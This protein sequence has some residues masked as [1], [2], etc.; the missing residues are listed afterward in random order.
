MRVSREK[1]AENR[2]KIL[3]TAGVM[4]RENGFN[5][6]GVA[7]IMKAC[8]LTHGGFYGHFQS[9]EELQLEVSRALIARVEIRWKELIA[10]SPERPL[11]ALLE[12]YVSWCA[13]DD[14][15]NSCV[16]VSLM[17]EVSRS[18]GAVREIFNDGLSALVSIL[19]EIVPGDTPEE[20]RKNGFTTLSSMMGAV[21]LARA[22]ENRELAG[23]FLSTM[24]EKLAP[25]KS[26]D[27]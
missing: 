27:A 13:V 5:G 24:R 23:Q 1:F 17:D 16:F 22:V 3:E 19:A 14:P 6:V 10:K 21:S 11:E 8:G 7:D 9:K 25:A 20:R 18:T 15:G 2:Q 12:H 4:F 26:A